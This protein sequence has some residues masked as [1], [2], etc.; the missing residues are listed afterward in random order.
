MKPQIATVSQKGYVH[1]VSSTSS[2]RQFGYRSCN[3]NG[4]VHGAW[5]S[6]EKREDK[7]EDEGVA[8][9][10]SRLRE[11]ADVESSSPHM[12]SLT[13]VLSS[14]PSRLLGRRSCWMRSSIMCS[15]YRTRSR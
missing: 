12:L 9:S 3:G 7:R 14:L 2:S 8:E 11:G 5:L 4:F 10:R 15:P 6:G 13:S 1:R